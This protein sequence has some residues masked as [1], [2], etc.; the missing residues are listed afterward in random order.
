[1][2][3]LFLLRFGGVP[4]STSTV[5]SWMDVTVSEFEDDAYPDPV[6]VLVEDL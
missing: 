4:D 1:M 3:Y 5:Q 2:I 6:F